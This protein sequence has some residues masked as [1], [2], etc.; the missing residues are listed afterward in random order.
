M[1]DLDYRRANFH[2]DRCHRCRDSCRSVSRDHRRYICRRTQ[3]YTE[4]K[5][6]RKNYSR[7]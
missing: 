6:E 7:L 1:T 3:R 4:T 5:K 2:A